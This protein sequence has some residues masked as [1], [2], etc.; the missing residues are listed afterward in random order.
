MLFHLHPM[1]GP[2]YPAVRQGPAT[3]AAAAPGR[4]APRG[5]SRPPPR[6]PRPSRAPPAC[7]VRRSPTTIRYFVATIF[8]RNYA[9]GKLQKLMIATSKCIRKFHVSKKFPKFGEDFAN[10]K[11]LNGTFSIILAKFQQEVIY[12]WTRNSISNEK[13]A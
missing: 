5:A 8:T 12:I 2:G 3:P 6:R 13:C 11:T 9:R 4:P 10:F 7:P 1:C